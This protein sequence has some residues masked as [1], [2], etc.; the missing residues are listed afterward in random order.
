[1][2]N[3]I[4]HTHTHTWLPAGVGGICIPKVL[5]CLSLDKVKVLNGYCHIALHLWRRKSRNT[6]ARIIKLGDLLH[7]VLNSK[8]YFSLKR[9]VLVFISFYA[10]FTS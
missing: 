7:A 10:A 4:V 2:P 5:A 6:Q 8:V 1:M 3:L 9:W